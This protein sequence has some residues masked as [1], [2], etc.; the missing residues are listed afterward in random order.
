MDNVGR[1]PLSL[2]CINDTYG[3]VELLLQHG[4]DQTLF[5]DDGRLPWH[6]AVQDE[7]ARILQV[8]IDHKCSFTH[9]LANGWTVYHYTA[10]CAKTAVTRVLIDAEIRAIDARHVDELGRIAM[11]VLEDRASVSNPGYELT[12]ETKGL[13]QKLIAPHCPEL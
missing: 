12:E 10:Y 11:D 13:L 8:Y 2:C 7:A 4:A 1:T 6:W 3:T 5:D 9:V